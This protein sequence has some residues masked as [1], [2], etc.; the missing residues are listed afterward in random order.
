MNKYE[1]RIERMERHLSVHPADYQT[2]I[3]LLR[4]R[5]EQIVARRMLRVNLMRQRIAAFK[6][7]M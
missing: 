5:S 7:L 4:R 3:S 6:R 1:E 2:V